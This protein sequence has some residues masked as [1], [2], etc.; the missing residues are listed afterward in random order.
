[1]KV[2][3][4][5]GC[6]FNDTYK[7]CSQCGKPLPEGVFAVRVTTEGMEEIKAPIPEDG[8]Q[9]PGQ[10]MPARPAV[11]AVMPLH[12]RV[13]G[14]AP[15]P[16]RARKRRSPVRWILGAAAVLILALS[17]VWGI[18]L[19]RNLFRKSSS[20]QRNS[21]TVMA[22]D[23]EELVGYSSSGKLV[24]YKT[25]EGILQ[26]QLSPDGTR[27]LFLTTENRLMLF[28]G[29]RFTHVAD[30]VKR[31]VFSF[32]SSAA[33]YMTQEN[34]LYLYRRGKSQ[35]A[36]VSVTEDFCLSPDG[37]AV[38]YV[39]ED[40]EDPKA[41]YYDG[42]EREIA[43]DA[44]PAAI[45]A[46]G[47]Y[48]YYCSAKGI[49]YVQKGSDADSRQK[50]ADHAENMSF[51][52]GGDEILVSDGVSTYFSEKGG[53]REKISSQPMILLPPQGIAWDSAGFYGIDSLKER[54]YLAAGTGGLT[55]YQ[56]TGKLE[57]NSL[58]R[59][60]MTPGLL[61]DGR[62]MVYT[63]NGNL[64]WMDL[65]KP[66]DRETKIAD[67]VRSFRVS[68]SGRSLL[69]IDEEG[70]TWFAKT[71]SSAR[72]VTADTID[73]YGASAG[74]NGGFVYELE[75][76]LYF[77]D[78]GKPVKVSGL[79]DD[80]LTLSGNG[81]WVMAECRNGDVFVSTNGKSYTRFIRK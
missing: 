55:V 33:A 40:G 60:V 12:P 41:Y 44:V 35:R 43:K 49:L 79:S 19:I 27:Y 80:V 5:C 73:L 21:L 10:E 28:D 31:F 42:R 2:C 75:G 32:D 66:E 47:R 30:G 72:R 4:N 53:E 11:P 74:L 54:C 7:F 37:K 34:E 9:A 17:L 67:N 16:P 36:A 81:F 78:G 8:P 57:L 23:N 50:L 22:S 56:L 26:G 29:S 38:A 1:M 52:A 46:G 25:D 63:K 45:S 65:K 62:T 77:T 64:Y 71:G 18:S 68:M 59:N 3:P 20:E 6:G 39:R 58:I 24:K 48:V 13:S 14:P 70:E 15:V 51:N 69:Y 61:S 76:S